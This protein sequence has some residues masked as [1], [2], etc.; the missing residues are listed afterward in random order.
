MTTTRVYPRSNISTLPIGQNTMANS[1]SVVIASDQTPLPIVLTAYSVVD[2][3]DAVLL[4][5]SIS[6]IPASAAAPLV[7]VASLAAAVKKIVSVDDI[8]EYIGVYADPLGACTLLCIM[9]LGGGEME[10]SIPI[11]TVIGLRNM[12]NAAISTGNIAINFLG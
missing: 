5:T 1:T 12:K 9:L 4:D 10:L 3:L 11:A 7:V 8:G 6:N 2:E